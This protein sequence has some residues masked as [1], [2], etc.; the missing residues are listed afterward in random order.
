VD[1]ASTEKNRFLVTVLTGPAKGTVFKLEG[2]VLTLGRSDDADITLPDPSL[3]RIHARF[4][5]VGKGAATGY[6]VEDFE[7]TNGTYVGG[8]RIDKPTFLTDGVRL[9]LGKRTIA[10]F[11][12]QDALEEQAIVSVHESALRDALTGAYNRRVFDDRL[13][14][15]LAFSVR[16]KQP[17]SLLLLDVDHFKRFND[18][19][20]HQAGDMVLQVVSRRIDETLRTED[21]FA[22]Y[23][24][25]EFGVLVRD[26][27][28]VGAL[29][30]GERLRALVADSPIEFEGRELSV[31]VSI[32]VA[33]NGADSVTAEQLIRE[34][35]EA[36]Y[37]AKE[38]GRDR[39]VVYE[40]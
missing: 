30:V 16:H 27:T 17:L 22:R 29:V 26:T 8:E 20:G 18:T 40:P 24:G 13:Q 6:L 3:S 19:H 31:T 36:L 2:D 1:D 12:L 23:G 35:D 33:C 25:E 14:G 4:L 21:V 32:G 5:R 9:G 15:E 7:S 28:P 38:R 37:Q 11:A 10:R 34:A 39:V